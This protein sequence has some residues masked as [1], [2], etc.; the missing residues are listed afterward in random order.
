MSD[1]DDQTASA[2]KMSLH[3]LRLINVGLHCIKDNAGVSHFII[4]RFVC[5]VWSGSTVVRASSAER[6]AFEK[7]FSQENGKANVSRLTLK[8][9]PKWPVTR[10][11]L[12]LV[13]LGPASSA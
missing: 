7:S 6:V 5:F 13:P 1:S 4:Y 8:N 10:V 9:S 2:G 12:L 3:E 11:T